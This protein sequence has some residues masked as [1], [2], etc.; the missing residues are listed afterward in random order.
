MITAKKTEK[1]Q[2]LF[3]DYL[4]AIQ[5]NR[6]PRSGNKMHSKSSVNIVV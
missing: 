4:D 2:R 1:K 5:Q 6:N 3:K